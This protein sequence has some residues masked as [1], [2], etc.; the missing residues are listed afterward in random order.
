M[1]LRNV[2]NIAYNQN[3]TTQERVRN[4]QT[5]RQQGDYISLVLFFHNKE[6]RLKI[7]LF[8]YRDR[9]TVHLFVRIPVIGASNKTNRR[10]QSYHC[11]TAHFS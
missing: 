2:G 1:W 9:K 4:T 6:S 7:K 8:Y 5:H 10:L 11:P 3:V